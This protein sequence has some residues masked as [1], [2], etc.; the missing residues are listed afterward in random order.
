MILILLFNILLGITRAEHEKKEYT[1]K[2]DEEMLPNMTSK[3]ISDKFT[4]LREL[5]SNS[6]DAMEK[7]ALEEFSEDGFNKTRDV[8]LIIKKASEDDEEVEY[9]FIVSDSGIGMSQA[10]LIKY[11][12]TMG[13]SGTRSMNNANET[14][15]GKFGMGFYSTFVIADKVKVITKK[16]GS[17]KAY[18]MVIS[19]D[20]VTYTIQ[21]VEDEFQDRTSGTD[22]HMKIRKEYKSSIDADEIKKWIYNNV[23]GDSLHNY[24]YFIQ[25]IEE[26]KSEDEEQKS[27]D[28][29]EKTEDEEKKSEEKTEDDEKK[30]EEQKTGEGDKK[31]VEMLKLFPWPVKSDDEAMEKYYKDIEGHGKVLVSEKKRVNIKQKGPYGKLDLVGLEIL[32][33]IPSFLDMRIIGME[34][35][36]KHLLFVN[37]QSIQLEEI[38][39]FLSP[40]TFIMRSSEIHVTST[41]EK[42]LDSK[43]TF[44][45]IITVISK[46]A[47][48]LLKPKLQADITGLMPTWD[49]YIKSGYAHSKNEKL[50]SLT[51]A[52][53]PILPF[54]TQKEPVLLGDL[55]S[56]QKEGEN[57]ILYANIIPVDLPEGVHHPLLDGIDEKIIILSGFLDEQ[58]AS[59]FEYKGKSMKNVITKKIE[60]LSRTGEENLIKFCKET[61]GALVDDVV[62]SQRLKNAPFSIKEK[63]S[64]FSAA[65]KKMLGNYIITKSV[66][67]KTIESDIILEINPD[68]AE[69][70]KI[71]EM[72]KNGKTQQA[73][74]ALR[75][76]VMAASVL[77][78]LSFVEKK[79]E[80]L[81]LLN[82]QRGLLD[83]ERIEI[84]DPK[85]S[86][87]G[88]SAPKY[89]PKEET[90]ASE[91]DA[92]VD[93]E[94]EENQDFEEEK[95]SVESEVDQE[96]VPIE[97]GDISEKDIAVPEQ[98]EEVREDL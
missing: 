3:L 30:S 83:M 36:G 74:D 34:T 96:T 95:T 18:E 38:P 73:Q 2:L 15:V 68:S 97:L 8:N 39:V 85:P 61:L 52:F 21:E 88:F 67:R 79:N 50:L 10:D 81:G 63:H 28:E 46:M 16:H 64:Q 65:H 87:E 44:Q 1:M 78:N 13:G 80:F 55:L 48:Q 11:L 59:S 5:I 69:I 12:G 17:E 40:M 32:L 47:I 57:E 92:E 51:E 24:R 20:K 14:F 77:C 26:Q 49:F 25:S 37:G 33:I 91:F 70:V 82:V 71:K 94:I 42:L 75:V 41:R 98:V 29:E 93:E 4:F 90:G 19:C 60:T 62:L 9:D 6:K 23:M 53:V 43:N 86:E 22:I 76:G 54:S 58:L 45:E 27:E 66:F 35:K 84:Q 7:L 72:I 31:K 89:H 56:E